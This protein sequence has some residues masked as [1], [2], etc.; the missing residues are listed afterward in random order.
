[1]SKLILMALICLVD[2]D[3]SAILG[4]NATDVEFGEEGTFDEIDFSN[5]LWNFQLW[6]LV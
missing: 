2:H 4:P 1:M 6:D 3:L 5:P